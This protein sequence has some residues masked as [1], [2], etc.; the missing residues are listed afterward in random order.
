MKIPIAI[1]FIAKVCHEANKA[2]CEINGD[3]AKLKT[4]PCMVP[5]EELPEFQQKKDKL[6]MVIVDVLK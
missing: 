2:L 4:H 5:F 1:G 3:N 6:F